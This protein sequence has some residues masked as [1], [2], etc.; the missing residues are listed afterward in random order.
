MKR[1]I[2]IQLSK[3][4][5]WKL[6]SK[7]TTNN[8]N[9]IFATLWLNCQYFSFQIEFEIIYK[10]WQ[11]MEFYSDKYKI[12]WFNIITISKNNAS[13]SR[14]KIL[15]KKVFTKN[16]NLSN[17]ICC[18]ILKLIVNI[19]GLIIYSFRTLCRKWCFLVAFRFYAIYFL[20]MPVDFQT[21]FTR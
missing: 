2:E 10:A 17:S 19:I 3:S 8:R 11:Y 21:H 13:K 12:K 15:P 14:N 7:E 5:F 20:S 9:G 4:L 16:T 1:H 6:Y 18:Q